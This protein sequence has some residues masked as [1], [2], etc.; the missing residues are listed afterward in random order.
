MKA[1]ASDIYIYIYIYFFFVT[2]IIFRAFL[3]SKSWTN[4]FSEKYGLGVRCSKLTIEI[5]EQGVKYVQ[6]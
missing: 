3:D 1:T 6:S 2:Q 5:L 4:H